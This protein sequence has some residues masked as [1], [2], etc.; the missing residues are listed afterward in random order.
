MT[1]ALLS[2]RFAPILDEV[3]KRACV[4]DAFVDK[5]VYRILLATVWAN[6]VMNPDEAGID[7]ADLERLHDVINAR[8]RDV[9]GSEDAIKD[10][11]RF[12]TSRAGEAAMD[13]ARVNKTHRELLLYFSSMILDPDGHRRWMA[14]VER[15]AGDS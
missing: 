12:V 11:F 9:L 3:E 4:A 6:V 1:D 15:R 14:E 8:A 2:A 7:I 10:C 5:E 13:Q